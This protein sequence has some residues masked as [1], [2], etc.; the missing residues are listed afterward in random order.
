MTSSSRSCSRCA[1]T[2][3]EEMAWTA[4]NEEKIVRFIRD[5]CEEFGLPHF[6]VSAVAKVV[7]HSARL[8]EDQRKL[9]TRFATVSDIIQEAAFWAG[10]ASGPGRPW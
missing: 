5:R 4:E 6:D 10:Q 1:P 3:A 9:T 2:F 8:V 7:E